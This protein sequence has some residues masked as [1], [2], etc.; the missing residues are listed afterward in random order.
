MKDIS[1]VTFQR[2]SLSDMRFLKKL[3]VKCGNME[4]NNYFFLIN[5]ERSGNHNKVET[6]LK[7]LAPI[8]F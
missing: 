1:N 6:N 2:H 8:S 4:K 3:L 7:S 5:L